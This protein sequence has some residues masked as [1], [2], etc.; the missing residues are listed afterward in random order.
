[1]DEVDKAAGV[2]RDFLKTDA[3]L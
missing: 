3:T 1:M 2:I